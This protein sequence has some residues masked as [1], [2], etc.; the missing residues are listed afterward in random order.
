MSERPSIK[1]GDS[2]YIGGNNL[3]AIVAVVRAAG[4]RHGDCEVVFSPDKPTNRDV[5]WTGESWEF[6]P[7]GDYGGYASKYSRLAT[8]VSLL[9]QRFGK[10]RR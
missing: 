5:R 6:V 2:I 8:Y 7:S 9:Q 1:P 3:A 4:D 10:K